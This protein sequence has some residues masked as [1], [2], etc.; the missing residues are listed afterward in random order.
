MVYL[1]FTLPGETGI[2]IH[3][4]VNGELGSLR[5]FPSHSV[6]L[7]WARSHCLAKAA[8]WTIHSFG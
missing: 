4:C 2:A 5:L 8:T 7:D 6:A 3:H 1:I